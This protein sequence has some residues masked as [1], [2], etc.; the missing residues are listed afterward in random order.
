M[1]TLL[2]P[3]MQFES[4]SK[5]RSSQEYDIDSEGIDGVSRSFEQK[6]LPIAGRMDVE[7]RK[8][9]MKDITLHNESTDQEF[10]RLQTRED[11]I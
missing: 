1:H 4:E 10:N 11:I 8:S 3:M 9:K 2:Q 6:Q 7:V 5:F